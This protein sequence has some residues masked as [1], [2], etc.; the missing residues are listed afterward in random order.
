MNRFLMLILYLLMLCVSKP[1]FAE[2]IVVGGSGTDLGTFKLLG[3]AF[4][5]KHPGIEVKVL[6]SM[7]SSGG[8]KALKHKK[9]DLALTSR[10]LKANEITDSINYR[11]YAS[12]PLVFVVARASTQ[13]DISTEQVLKFY[14][15]DIKHWPDGSVIRPILRPSSDSDTKLIVNTLI[16]CKKC[17]YKAYQ[18]RGVPIALT[19]QESADMV[20][21]VPGALGTSTLA[22]I[23]SEK[24]SIKPLSLNGVIASAESLDNHLYPMFKDLYLVYNKQHKSKFLPDFLGFLSSEKARSILLNTGHLV[25]KSN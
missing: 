6:P 9:I 24:K 15:G 3:Q 22:L 13:K 10:P 23:R 7:G 4:S 5:Q 14:T 19:D 2:L 18:R 12:T 25:K 16:E 1:L 17:F 21:S 20:T 11:H 8:I